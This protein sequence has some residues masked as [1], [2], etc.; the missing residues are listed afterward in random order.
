MEA[1]FNRRSVRKYAD[2]PVEGE[3][4]EKILRAA[5]QAPSAGNQQ[6][7]E[8]LVV[9]DKESLAKLAKMS[10]YAGPI[11][12][13][14]LAI[15][16]LGN[17]DGMMFPESWEHDMGAAAEN[18]LLE[19]VALGLGGVWLGVLPFEERMDHIRGQ[20]SLPEKVTPFAVLAVGYPDKEDAN[21][22]VDR[23]KEERVHYE[24]Y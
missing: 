19:A 23:Y 18:A 11:A 14:P 15:I 22:F 6:P 4:V 20:F 7:W 1:I 5:M 17:S 8:F 3:K 16:M 24:A 2:Q 21:H 9:Q 10:P 13:A 12:K